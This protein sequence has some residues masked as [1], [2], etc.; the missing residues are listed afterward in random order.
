MFFHKDNRDIRTIWGHSFEWTAQHQAREQMRPLT[1][2]YDLLGAECLDKLDELSPPAKTPDLTQNQACPHRRDLYALLS[3]HH[4]ADPSLSALWT[5]LYTVPDWVD[6]E[7][8]AR[9]QDVFTRYGVPSIVSLTFQSLVGGMAGWRVVETLSRTGGFGVKVAR[10][11]LLE[12]FQHILQVTRDVDSVKPGG[13]GFASSVR[14]RLLHAHVRR[15]I[16]ALSREKPGYFDVDAWGVPVSDLDSIGTILSFSAAL[17]WIGLPRQ[18]I[19]LREQEIV[20]YHA[21][22][23][24]IAYL[25]GT[26]TEPWLVDWRRSK[27]MLESLMVAELAP[28]EMSRTLA[29]NTITALS[30]QPPA[31]VSR[32]F[33]CAE[34]HWLIGRELADALGIARPSLLHRFL[35]ATQCLYLMGTCYLYRSIP[36]WDRVKN[37]RVRKVLYRF[38]VQ[39]KKVGLGQETVFDFKYVPQLGLT[40]SPG[41]QEDLNNISPGLKIPLGLAVKTLVMGAFAWV[42][43]RSVVR[44]AELW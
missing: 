10:R 25:L 11:R 3:Q 2:T 21:L 22:W 15:K 33:M 16:L 27:V 42:T 5:Q 29:N 35:M 14:V 4:A 31:Y 26:P 12:T 23:R 38:T 43:I 6:W 28:S 44:W 30:R 1:T 37:Q 17:V 19:F 13:D 36:S 20:D 40:T 41:E 34:A 24:W 7:Q 8:I 9:G 32:E 18:G 39:D